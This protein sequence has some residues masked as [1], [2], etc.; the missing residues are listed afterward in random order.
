MKIH[1][2]PLEAFAPKKI[3]VKIENGELHIPAEEAILGKSRHHVSIPGKFK[4]PFRIDMTVKSKFIRTNQV[5]SQL[6][7]Y[8]GKGQIYFNGGHTSATDIFTREEITPCALRYNEMPKKDY[9]D[10]SIMYGSEIMWA[11][12]DNQYCFSSVKMP[13]IKFLQENELP[14]LSANGL[15]IA[16]CG[17]TDT[18]L[19]IKSLTVTEYDN[20][21][22]DIP[23][24]MENLPELSQFELYVRGLPPEVHDELF[25]TDEYLLKDMKS[26]LKFRRTIDKHGHLLYKSP[27]GFQYQIREYG[28]GLRHQTNWVQSP[29]KP[30]YTNKIFSRLAESS[31]EFAEKIFNKSQICNPHARDCARRTI[32]EFNGK[33]INVCSGTVKFNMLPSEFEDM[34][35]VVA[36]AG[37]I[38]KEE[39][40]S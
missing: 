4:L 30:D 6:T 33:S 3:K 10:I 9:T 21:E 27:C 35:K 29:N 5:T 13:Y 39:K 25:K 36:A 24:E 7:L 37:E 8:I 40:E 32:V 38:I 15:G 14:E 12:V 22:P 11:S 26:S 16:M 18:K 28:V 23:A 2:I 34:R 31:P 20:D 19:T 1:D 17:G